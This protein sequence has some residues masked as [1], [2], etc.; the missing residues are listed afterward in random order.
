MR[1]IYWFEMLSLDGYHEGDKDELSWHNVD[2][3]FHDFAV[4]QLRQTDTLLFGRKTYEMMAEFWPSDAARQVD[5]KTAE[6]MNRLPKVVVSRT[7][8]TADW[9]PATIISAEV[10][11]ALARLKERPGQDIALL[12]S[13]VLATSLL[14]SGV[15][16]ELR[17]MLNPVVLGRGHAILAGVDAAKLALTGVREFRAG[18]VL[19]TYEPSR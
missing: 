3:E 19:L 9:A 4:Q 14:G 18:N 16:D 2:A 7:L 11:A 6:A 5:P 17:L 10:P 13:S 15:I 8:T 1:K 12:G